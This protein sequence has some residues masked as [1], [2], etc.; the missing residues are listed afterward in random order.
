MPAAVPKKKKA[1]TKKNAGVVPKTAAFLAAYVKTA[2]LTK[3]AKA[4][5]IERA[6]HYRWLAADEAYAIAF[7]AA[8]KQAAQVLEDEATR[9]AHEGV[10][11]PVIYHG[12]LCYPLVRNPKTGELEGSKTPLMKR[13]YSDQVLMF[14][15]RGFNPDKYRDSS[16]VEVTGTLDLVERLAAGRA[17]LRKDAGGE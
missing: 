4:A 11:E 10:L 16:K 2:S 15:L 1:T 5:K 8:Q 9:R 12:E 6:M 7:A 17:R 14:L 3:A 13:T